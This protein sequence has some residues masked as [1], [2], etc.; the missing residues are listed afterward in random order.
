MLENLISFAIV[1]GLLTLLPGIDTAQILRAATIGGRKMAYAT[2]FGILSGVWIWGIAAAIGIS[3]LLVASEVAYSAVK[4]TGAIY[5]LF[6]GLKMIIESRHISEESIKSQLER[7]ISPWKSFLRALFIT[8]SN[9]K[10]GVFYIAVLP[11][12]LPDTLPAVVGGFILA[13]IHNL[14]AFIWLSL[15]IIGTGFAKETLRN[16]R[17]QK[18]VERVSGIALIGFGIKVALEKH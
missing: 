5:L 8:L 6:L 11:Q 13:S 9:P 12:F 3:A 16:P 18:V 14:L 15:L 1:A 7:E 4:W 2:L 10:N 17:V